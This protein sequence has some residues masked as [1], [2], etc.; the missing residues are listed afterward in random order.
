MLGRADKYPCH[1]SLMLEE[2]LEFERVLL[3]D[4]EIV[5][6]ID[7]VG[8][9][10]LAGP[11]L[12]GAV[13]LGSLRSPPAGLDDSKRLTAA[14]RS[15]LE[16]PIRTWCDDWSLGSVSAGEI[17]KWGLRLALSVAVDRALQELRVAPTHVLIDGPLNLLEVPSD[18]LPINEVAPA[19][20]HR[21][22]SSTTIVKG[23][24]R[25]AT[26][27]AASVLAKV[28]R[29]AMMVM[30]HD[31]CGAYQWSSNKGYG[32]QGHIAALRRIG[33]HAQHRISWKLT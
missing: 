21:H 9:G 14:K 7:E 30:L 15:S 6:G 20:T 10:A 28:A 24:Q 22:L 3:D 13:V 25:S 23:D 12:V 32:T 18:T 19:L 2:L 4:G 26:I 29:D 17:D 11:M 1:V 33:P 5:V 31:E 8:R 27:A 16:V